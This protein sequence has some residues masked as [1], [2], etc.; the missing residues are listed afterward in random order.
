M[1]VHRLCHVQ[2][3]GKRKIMPT[4]EQ[5]KQQACAVIEQRGQALI[6]I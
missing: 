5:L 2:G 1:S 3:L 6:E 4:K